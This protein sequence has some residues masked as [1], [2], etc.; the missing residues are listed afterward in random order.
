MRG[1][2]FIAYC[3]DVHGPSFQLRK[4]NAPGCGLAV[5]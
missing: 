4:S 5:A 3:E 2:L 1:L